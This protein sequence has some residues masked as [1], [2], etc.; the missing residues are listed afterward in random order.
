M[1]LDEGLDL[2]VERRGLLFCGSGFSANCLSF[3]DDALGT[4]SPLLQTLK[5]ELN[6]E[7]TDLAIAAEDYIKEKGENGLFSLLTEKYSVRNRPQAVDDILAHHWSRIYTT[8]YDDTISLSLTNA[9]CKHYVANNTEY[10][11]EIREHHNN[12]IWV[13]HLHGA[14][15]KWEFG[16]SFQKSCILGAKSY[17]RIA[18]DFNWQQ[19]LNEDYSKAGVIF[20]IGFSNNDFYLAQHLYSAGASKNK[21]FF[22]NAEN[23]QDD[24]ELIAR[25]EVFGAS[26]AIG[27][28]RFAQQLTERA[29]ISPESNEI[30]LDSFKKC[31][32]P[33]S[34]PSEVS[35]DC[36]Y[37]FLVNGKT[38]PP[39]HY[40]DI[41]L[42]L[43]HYRAK[44]TKVD[45]I[46]EFLINKGKIALILGGICSGKTTVWAEC[47][48]KLTM[49]GQIVFYLA[50]K[51][52][53]LLVEVRNIINQYP[54]AILAI[55]NCFSLKEDDFHEILNIVKSSSVKLLLT[56]RTLIYDNEP[57]VHSA[58][59]SGTDFQTFDMEELN[60]EESLSL[61][62]GANRTGIWGKERAHYNNRNKLRILQTD[63]HRRLSSFLLGAFR[64]P[65]IRDRFSS[66]F[67]VIKSKGG[68][69]VEHTL[70]IALYL[71]NIEGRVEESILS[72]LTRGDA[73]KLFRNI[74]EIE[75]FIAYDEKTNCFDVLPSIN[76]RDALQNFFDPRVIVDSI[77]SVVK[78][79]ENL[80]RMPRYINIFKQFMRYTQIKQ[81]VT[82]SEQ[83]NRFFD[84][85]S[86]LPFCRVLVMFW[87]QWSM[88]MRDQGNYI[89][90]AQ[91]LDEAYGIGKGIP[92]F[93]PAYLDDQK[94]GLLLESTPDNETSIKYLQRFNEVNQLLTR[95]IRTHGKTSHNYQTIGL[96]TSFFD[97]AIP[98]LTINTNKTAIKKAL[99]S[100]E[101][102]VNQKIGEQHAGYVKQSME[103]AK[104]VIE[105][106]IR[107]L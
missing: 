64:S 70:I 91:Y 32:L 21:V 65:S 62:E 73:L 45:E 66:E 7:Y 100:L 79:M 4:A 42:D 72:E 90:A 28:E 13:V 18:T 81:I 8:N 37:H 46:T 15:K 14:L 54:S 26:L 51:Y 106:S 101:R 75:A 74:K 87:L 105:D 63:H 25:Q 24:R 33:D 44:R 88:A 5:E 84:T 43:D 97:K 17:L 85:L 94:A 41:L 77:T 52:Q 61:I 99:E 50:S 78:D 96:L 107:R 16:E 67:S 76:A 35:A 19:E 11:H 20:F 10:P 92:E 3:N 9:G 93:D 39:A 47:L 48:Y 102:I 98:N 83:Q 40:H 95:C 49:G 29:K 71:Q 23:A 36:Q 89:K 6:Y 86:T 53:G 34:Y 30:K 60:D 80:R 31:N 55:D 59:Q 12:K 38:D 82:V 68:K 1:L 22:I 69:A 57:N 104:K 58:L 2:V 103:D 27:I 56:S